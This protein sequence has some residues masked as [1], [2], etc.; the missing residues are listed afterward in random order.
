MKIVGIGNALVDLLAKLPDDSLLKE[1]GL[2]PGSMNLINEEQRVKLFSLLREKEI[3]LVMT[4]GGSVSN[5]MLALQKLGVSVGFIGKTGND[6]YGKFY[7]DEM[8]NYGVNLH[9]LCEEMFSGTALCLITPDGER[10]FTTY[11]GAAADMRK[12]DLEKSILEQYSLLYVEGYL[13][14]NHELIE[15]AL[16]MAK[17]LGLK[18]ALDLA[19]YNVVEAEKE[20]LLSLIAKYVDVLFANEDEAAAL[21][22]KKP[23]Q[24]LCEISEMVDIAVVKEGSK[25]SW[26]KRKNELIH[27]PCLSVLSPVDTT[28][29]GD[30]YAA[31]FLAGLSQGL[32]LSICAKMGTTLAYHIIQVVGTKL[33]DSIWEDIKSKVTELTVK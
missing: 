22:G 18:T 19:S 5:S 26:I 10:T 29:A 28:A 1:L 4:T 3:D 32:D 24:A 7:L 13:I 31:G 6:R 30:Y 33:H 25:G 8:N 27:V 9:L 12:A 21:T 17:S 23:E 2:S 11:L 20:F 16:S 15:G 14:Q